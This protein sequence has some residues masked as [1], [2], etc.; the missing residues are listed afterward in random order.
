MKALTAT[1]EATGAT[2][3]ATLTNHR[4]TSDIDDTPHHLMRRG[5]PFSR[6]IQIAGVHDADEACLLARCG[7]HAV[8]LPLRLP[9]N[10]EDIDEAAAARLVA[11]LPPVITP[12]AITYMDD[13]DEADAFCTML[14]VG[15]LQLHGAIRVDEMARLRRLRPD[16][17]IIKSLV[18]REHGG[19]DNGETLMGDVQAF[20]PHVDAFITDTFA[21]ETGASG[22]T[23]KTHDWAVS[24]ALVRLS[25]RPV[26]LAGGLHP[27]NVREAVRR[28]CPAG[29]DAHTGVEGPDGRK[30][31]GLVRRFVAEALAGFALMA[32]P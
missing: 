1:L 20:A 28:V 15:H 29:V 23:G 18:V 16:L 31:E 27:G 14:G 24:A 3:D 12:V 21:P 13:A 25:P 11:G 30:D 26:I 19:M 7:V 32:T 8:G 6:C 9:V 5:M 22:A 10:A 17:F 2:P 4:H